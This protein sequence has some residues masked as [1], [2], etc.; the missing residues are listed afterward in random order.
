[1]TSHWRTGYKRSAYRRPIYR[2]VTNP[3]SYS[4]PSLLK[5]KYVSCVLIG[6]YD[7]RIGYSVMPFP[8]SITIS[9]LISGTKFDADN[10]TAFKYRFEDYEHW[11]YTGS[12]FIV[13]CN[14]L[15]LVC[16]QYDTVVDAAVADANI[17]SIHNYNVIHD[18]P[19]LRLGRD[20][21]TKYTDDYLAANMP[22]NHH[23][24]NIK[25]V[26]KVP[27]KHQNWSQQAAFP[28][29]DM[30]PEAWHAAMGNEINEAEVNDEFA[31]MVPNIKNPLPLQY[32]NKAKDKWEVSPAW[33]KWKQQLFIQ[34]T[35]KHYHYFKLRLP[36]YK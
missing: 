29:R 9:M 18:R 20:G 6:S 8:T 2:R 12:S 28:W 17:V 27:M 11:K 34:C 5:S 31:F 22:G 36:E 26:Q 1:M 15:E 10:I 33:K 23:G 35:V 7:S 32:A 19:C 13:K 4:T 30:R 24:M 3:R 25:V 21:F 14:K 16:V